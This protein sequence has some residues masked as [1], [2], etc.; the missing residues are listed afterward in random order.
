MISYYIVCKYK[1]ISN[2]LHVLQ[3]QQKKNDLN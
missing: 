2:I 3:Q 1:Y